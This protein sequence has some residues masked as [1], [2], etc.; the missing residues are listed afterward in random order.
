[1][2]TAHTP[3]RHRDLVPRAV[4][5]LSRSYRSISSRQTTV[6]ARDGIGVSPLRHEPFGY[7]RLTTTL[8]L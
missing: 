8:A 3:R 5:T 2:V 1:L 7:Q 4:A 6:D